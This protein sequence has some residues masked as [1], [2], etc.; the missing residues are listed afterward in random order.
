[1]SN[2]FQS[3]RPVHLQGL[4]MW[5]SN[6]VPYCPKCKKNDKVEWHDGE[7]LCARCDFVVE[8]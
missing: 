3:S 5:G 6:D 8:R 4:T 7:Y 2:K 1:M